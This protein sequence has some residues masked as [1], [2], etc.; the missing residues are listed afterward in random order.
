MF[1]YKI[2]ILIFI[3]CFEHLYSQSNGYFFSQLTIENGLS[4]N[5]VNAIFKDSYGFIWIGTLDGIDRYDGVEVRPYFH[6]NRGSI[7]HVLVIHED[8]SKNLWVGT[9][10]G[11]FRYNRNHDS[12]ERVNLDTKNI[13]IQTLTILPDSNLFVGTSNGLYVVNTNS[14]DSKKVFLGKKT[15]NQNI[16]I[17]GL[18]VDDDNC[19]ITTSRGLCRYS[20]LDQNS[21]WFQ[22]LLQPEVEYNSF[23]SLSKI[24]NTLYLG[25]TN[26]GVLEFDLSNK[27]FSKG[28]NIDNK[29]ILNIASDNKELLFIGTNGGGLKVFNVFTGEIENIVADPND[30]ESLSS[31]S[32]YSFFLDKEGRYWVGT[33]SAGISFTKNLTGNFNVHP[34]TADFPHINKS[35][36]SFYF[37]P[38]GSQYFGTR[39]G[40]AQLSKNGKLNFFQSSLDENTG[41]RSNIILSIFPFMDDLL[42]GTYGGGISRFSIAEQKMKPFLESSS[43]SQGNI[44]AFAEDSSDDLWISSFNGLHRYSAK[45]NSLVNFNSRNSDLKSD[46]IFEITFDSKERMW[47]GTMTGTYVYA[48]KENK[49]ANIDLSA[50]PNNTFKTN[51]IYEDLGKNIWI[52]TER[53]GLIMIDS[54]LTQS[55]TFLEENGLPDHSICAIVEGTTGEYWIS[56]LKGLCKYSNLTQKFTKYSISE[57]LP[58]LVFTPAATHLDSED[59]IFFGNEKGLVYFD[60]KK[61]NNNSYLS[62]IIITDFFISGK[63]VKPGENTVLQKRIEETQEIHLTGQMNN[64]GFRFVGLNYFREMDNNYQCK[65]EGYDN[66][67]RDNGSSN[68]VFYQNLKTGNYIFKVRNENQ[69]DANTARITEAKIK[70][71]I[72]PTFFGSLYFYIILFTFVLVA[73]LITAYYIKKLP[74]RVKKKIDL[75][76]ELEKYK[77][78]KIPESRSELIVTELK[79]HMQE[80]KLYLN[81]ELKL[82]DLSREINY[83]MNEISQVLNQHLNLSFSDFVNKYR[84][85]EIKELMAIGKHKKFTLVAIAKQCGFNSKTSFYRVFKKETNKTPADYLKEFH[86]DNEIV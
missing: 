78:A 32:I 24:G 28:V 71:I 20:L 85:E 76:K 67:W 43:L 10:T 19:W 55:T 86:Y 2:Y 30:P 54:S 27:K 15:Q 4:N 53:G 58:S 66:D 80:K 5:Q 38:E 59:K 39:N 25:T 45:D 33:Y 6:E 14:F 75:S 68:T 83:P 81:P 8:L 48:L 64:I 73:V 23:T 22:C 9:T 69:S 26:I 72:R 18:F 65:L 74:D 1:W 63:K 3:F 41:L 31:N 79:R 16:N 13:R 11:L 42:I 40:F 17:T 21:E 34:L 37:S 84:V 70:I 46:Q 47:V 50:I 12:F 7:E 57:G 82:A 52:C 29:I 51:Y 61:V 56:T 60:P 35:I 77:G 49:L 44:Y 36:R 62:K